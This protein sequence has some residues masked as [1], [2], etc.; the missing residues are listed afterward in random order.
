MR[1]ETADKQEAETELS[2]YLPFYYF[3]EES[4]VRYCVAGLKG[5]DRARYNVDCVVPFLAHDVKGL[6]QRL[7]FCAELNRCIVYRRLVV[8]L[9]QRGIAIREHER[10]HGTEH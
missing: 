4:R 6:H 1:L 8:V 5:G 3:Q 10:A 9:A 2:F 7:V